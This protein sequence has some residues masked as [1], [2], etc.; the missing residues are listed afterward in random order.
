MASSRRSTCIE[1]IHGLAHKR[2]PTRADVI[3]WPVQRRACGRERQAS[4]L[5]S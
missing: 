1:D 4:L 2:R 3:A 5:P